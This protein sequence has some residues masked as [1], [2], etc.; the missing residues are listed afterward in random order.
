MAAAVCVSNG[1]KQW[2]FR[3]ND[4]G[5]AVN[6]LGVKFPDFA[7]IF[8]RMAERGNYRVTSQFEFPTTGGVK[9]PRT[10]TEKETDADEF[11]S[12]W[13]DL[14]DEVVTMGNLDRG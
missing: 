4:D 5:S 2:H 10:E 12:Q 13:Y 9:M 1:S 11:R 6:S 14:M 7:A 8:I 3:I